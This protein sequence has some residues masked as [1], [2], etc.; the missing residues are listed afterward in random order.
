MVLMV[1]DDLDLMLGAIHPSEN[2]PPLLVDPNA[3]EA[4]QVPLELFEP[5]AGWYQKVVDDPRLIDHAQLA[6]CPF[7]NVTGES[8]N[9]QAAENAFGG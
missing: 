7:L 1:V 3:P 5:V 6:P 9:P 2:D 4:R 8:S